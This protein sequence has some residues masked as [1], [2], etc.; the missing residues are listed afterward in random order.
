MFFTLTLI[1]IGIY[2]IEF[3][4]FHLSGK[5]FELCFFILQSQTFIVELTPYSHLNLFKYKKH[6]N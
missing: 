1:A 3:K 6:N 2:I 5:I 4:C